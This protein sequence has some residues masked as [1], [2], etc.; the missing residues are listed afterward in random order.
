MT[1]GFLAY[2]TLAP[3]LIFLIHVAA[4]RILTRRGPGISPQL[5]L[6][7]LILFLNLPLVLGTVFFSRRG[8][9]LPAS[10]EETLAKLV[11]AAV[12]FNGFG[13]AYFH[14]FNLS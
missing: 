2:V 12:V 3:V 8:G 13:Y 1:P 9:A 6:M 7:K 5:F 10:P 4:C 14:L 11:F